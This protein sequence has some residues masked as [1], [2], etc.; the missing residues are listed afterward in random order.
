MRVTLLGTGTSFGVPMIGCRCAVCTS[1][2]PRNVRTR[3]SAHITV[4][5]DLALLVDSSVD[6]RQ[7]ALMNNVTRVDAVFFTHT[8]SDHVNGIDELRSFNWL[9]RAPVHCF[10]RRDILDVIAQR[11]AHCFET[12]QRG[13]GVPEIQLHPVD[14]PFDFRGVRVTPIPVRHGILDILGWRFDD[15]GYITDASEIP[16]AS[17]ALLEGVEVLIVNALRRTPHP[18]HMNLDEAVAMIAE[19]NPGAA[20]LTHLTHEFEYSQLEAETPEN[21]H[22]AYDGMTFEFELA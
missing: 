18:T 19:I 14:G 17:I 2:E 12:P 8:H 1:P 13:A 9:Q 5:E 4:S 15:F 20:Y 3:A 7:Q 16:E 21:V 6:L 11:F 10:S 22:P